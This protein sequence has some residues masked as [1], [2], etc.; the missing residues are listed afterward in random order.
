L[1]LYFLFRK[2][3]KKEKVIVPKIP[4]YVTATRELKDLEKKELWQNNK[5]K[6][7]Y[8][9]LTDIVRKFV[10]DELFIQAM[11]TTTDEL[12]HLLEAENKKQKLELDKEVLQKLKGLLS[13]ADFVKFAK[14]KPYESD[15]N[16]H[17][18]DAKSVIETIHKIVESKKKIEENEVQ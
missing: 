15:I 2:K 3:E 17:K 13:Q 4:P 9:E 12:M 5:T 7:Y 16:G 11:E 8:S 6:E 18:S 1:A 14:Q 10:G